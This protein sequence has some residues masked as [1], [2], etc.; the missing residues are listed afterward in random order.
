MVDSLIKEYKKGNKLVLIDIINTY[1]PMIN[2]YV[3]KYYINGYNDEDLEQLAI[4]EMIKSLNK[5]DENKGFNLTVYLNSVIENAFKRTLKKAIKLNYV[6]SIDNP[7]NDDGD[8]FREVIPCE[9]LV[10][11]EVINTQNIS[12]LRNAL[13]NLTKEEREFILNVHTSRG[14]LTK[15]SN[16]TGLSYSSCKWKKKKILKKLIENMQ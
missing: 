2:K 15:Y 16:K 13:K 14:G 10:D 5:Y 1:R 11:E 12:N 4:Y 7:I 6:L 9:I 3:S 8:T